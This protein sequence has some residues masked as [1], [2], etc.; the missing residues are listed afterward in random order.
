MSA[1]DAPSTPPPVRPR[2]PGARAIR[3]TYRR[4]PTARGALLVTFA[5]AVL[6]GLGF[7]YN[8]R[9]A[10]G[11]TLL[12][13]SAAVAALALWFLPHDLTSAVELAADPQRSRVSALAL[14]VVLVAWS[15]VVVGTFVAVRPKPSVRWKLW[16][17]SVLVVGLC[18]TVALPTIVAARY[19]MVQASLV[20][21]V[22][23]TERSATRPTHVTKEDPWG[24]RRRLNILLLGGD[25]GQGRTG[26]RTDS[27]ILM[28]VNTKTGRAVTFSLPR[29]MQYAQ[30]P[31][32]T[33]LKALYPNGF[34]GPGDVNNYLL[35]AVYRDVPLLHPDVLAKSDNPGADALKLA[36]EGSTGLS[37]DYY[38]LVNLKGFQ[39]LVDAMGGVTV[40]I[41]TPVAV[42][43]DTDA[44][45]PPDSY[46]EPGADQHLNG[47]QALWFARGRYGSDD[48]Q[49]MDRQRCLVDA[50]VGQA[51]PLNLL[52]RFEAIASAS[53][54][55]IF[56]DLPQ[57]L[58]PALVDLA[59]EVKQ[60]RVKS[61]VFKNS[62]DF[63]P[64]YPDY[65]QLR[66]T[67]H[68]AVKFKSSGKGRKN[69]AREDTK[70]AC[71]FQGDAG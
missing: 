10:L 27:V 57:E 19:A 6:P 5:G 29:N 3:P 21:T 52:R 15:T 36:V 49:R 65:E 32:D 61:V 35:N 45:I 12:A 55:M 8:G 67:V 59:L 47:F 26:V 9:R 41:N 39:E 34:S 40:N 68:E 25:G 42:G 24:G 38:F 60:H 20:E 48:Y 1:V 16:G 46:L 23:S 31:D 53:K 2:R 30:F 63:T 17:S 33:P 54:D 43:G 64:A 28:S 4:A 69:P 22:F 18:L 44:G 37:V 70:A 11:Y 50:I 13:G 58:L 71:A 66:E 62:A 14:S 7:V 51:K 56:T